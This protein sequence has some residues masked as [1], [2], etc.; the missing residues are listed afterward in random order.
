[1]RDSHGTT[2]PDT[3]VL[4]HGLWLTALSW[5]GWA[6]RYSARG[7][8]VIARSWPG[9]EG[10]IEQVRRDPAPLW[11]LGV[12]EIVDHYERIIRELE[13][14]PIVMGH[15]FG[16]LFTEILL[17]RGFGAAAV[18][19][20]P[21]APQGLLRTPLSTLRVAFPALSNPANVH[22]VAPLTPDQFRYAFGNTLTAEESA[23]AYAR[24]AAPGPA[25]VLFQAG[26][27]NFN[28]HAATHV[29]FRN[30]NRA[31]LLLIAG[32]QDH[33]SPASLTADNYRRYRDSGA[34][35]DYKEYPE[36]SHFTV[37]E[38]GWEEIADYALD[39]AVAH[40]KT[41]RPVATTSQ[42]V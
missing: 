26:L 19:I 41:A 17:D 15:S 24:Y 38:R 5:E 4:I 7:Y 20:A 18:A 13:R 12:T 35:T 25:R 42:S 6:A 33:V 32:G 3:V 40:A 37:G 34:I 27:A 28:P 22:K 14:P 21:A 30:A 8:R 31:P 10:D 16:R 36:R 11:D 29:D 9:L 2:A 23:A 39:W 1:M